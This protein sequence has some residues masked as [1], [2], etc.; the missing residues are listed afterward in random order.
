MFYYYFF[1]RLTLLFRLSEFKRL[2]YHIPVIESE[3]FHEH[4]DQV[5]H[6][7][8]SHNGKY[9]ATSSKDGFVKV[10]ANCTVTVCH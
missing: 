3:V 4:K 5:L 9:F 1:L 2:Y 8:F 6:V 10:H 7:S